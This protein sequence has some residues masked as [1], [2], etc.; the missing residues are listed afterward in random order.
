MQITRAAISFFLLDTHRMGRNSLWR[1]SCE[2]EGV[3]YRRGEVDAVI[4]T[5]ENG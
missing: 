2:I 4:G 5:S 3:K 1:E